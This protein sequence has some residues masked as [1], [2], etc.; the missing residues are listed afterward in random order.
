M[1]HMYKK[2][3]HRTCIGMSK[4]GQ[5]HQVLICVRGPYKAYVKDLCSVGGTVPLYLAY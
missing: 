5:H 3:Q 2:S 1:L 4:L